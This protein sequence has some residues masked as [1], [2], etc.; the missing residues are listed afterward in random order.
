MCWSLSNSVLLFGIFKL[1]ALYLGFRKN[2]M[3]T[4]L[5]HFKVNRPHF[6]EITQN[7]ITVSGK[8]WRILKKLYLLLLHFWAS[9]SL[10]IDSFFFCLRKP[11]IKLFLICCT[12]FFLSYSAIFIIYQRINALL[13]SYFKFTIEP[14]SSIVN[15]LTKLL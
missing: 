2:N 14:S 9:T 10:F 8:N 1:V 15:E 7:L 6:Q 12:D 13:Q 3:F 5:R 11:V 4:P